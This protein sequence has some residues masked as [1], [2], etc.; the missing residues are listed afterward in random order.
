MNS[1]AKGKKGEREL[2][3]MKRLFGVGGNGSGQ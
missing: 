2:S 1:N 3:S